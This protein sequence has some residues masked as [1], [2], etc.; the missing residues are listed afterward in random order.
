M[1][2]LTGA[3]RIFKALQLQESDRVPFYEAP[4]RKIRE[5]ILPGSSLHE[6]VEY[7]DLDAVGVSDRGLPGYRI[8]TLDASHFRNQW[9]TIMQVTSELDGPHPVEAAIRTEKEFDTWHPPDPD[10]PWRYEMLAELV[11]RYKGQRAIIASFQDPFN[12]ANEVRGAVN[13]YMD[14]V[15][16]PDLVDRLA[17]LI[18]DYYLRYIRNCIKVG[19]DIIL[20]GGDYATTKWPMLSNEHFS[21]HVI[22][23]LKALVDEAKSR[24]AYFVKHTDG[25]IIPIIDMIIDTGINGLHPIDPN[26]GMNLGEV[27]EKYGHRV[28]LVGNVDCAYTLTWGTVEEV[29]E[30]V[31]RCIKQAA[32]GGGYICMSS[33]SIHSAVKTENYVEMVKAIRDYGKYPISL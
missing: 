33:N 2:T 30:D 15:K 31:K 27:K 29:R 20:F 13:H 4:N 1:K 23:V 9:G 6:A 5:E 18:R 24:G 8:E 25:N 10:E 16:N 12:V 26:A 19:A 17:E 21:K 14:F 7:F 11:K 22:P 28:C 32:R 3:E